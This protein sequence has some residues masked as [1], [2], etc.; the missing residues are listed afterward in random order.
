MRVGPSKRVPPPAPPAPRRPVF[1]AH[2][3]R[4][5]GPENMLGPP[6]P[7]S[8]GRQPGPRVS[9]LSLECSVPARPAPTP[10]A[11]FLSPKETRTLAPSRWHITPLP[12]RGSL[13][14][15]AGT[16]GPRRQRRGHTP[17]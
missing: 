4:P 8:P 3:P 1:L 13:D 17:G 2:T 5:T 6:L 11:S 10:G 16:D 14:P 15:L 12:V 9:E 7:P